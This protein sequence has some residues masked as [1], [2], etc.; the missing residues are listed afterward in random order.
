MLFIWILIGFLTGVL[1]GN[2]IPHF[3]RGITRQNYPS[4]FG[5]GP[6]TNLVLGWLGLVLASIG[7]AWIITSPDGI[8]ALAAAAV[9]VL[10]IGLFHATIGA[11]GRNPQPT[12]PND[13]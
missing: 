7:F 8:A 1:A 12:K 10:A 13:P 4:V 2:G 5:S 9:G 6:A 11:F 3:I